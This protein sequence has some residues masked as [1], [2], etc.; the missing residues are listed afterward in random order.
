MKA[1]LSQERCRNHARR[2]AVARCPECG[3]YFCRECVTEHD[4]RL[5]CASCLSQ[6]SPPGREARHYLPQFG[7]LVLLLASLLTLWLLFYGL[8]AGLTKIPATIH[9]GTLWEEG[10]DE[11]E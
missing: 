2:E 7:R 10:Q 1:R 8:G 9:Q 3:H 4:Q 6:A 11:K 5:L